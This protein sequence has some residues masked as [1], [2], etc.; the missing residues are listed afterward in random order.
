MAIGSQ[1][2]VTACTG[3]NQVSWPAK[4][5]RRAPRAE[6]DRLE[7]LLVVLI[8]DGEVGAPAVAVRRLGGALDAVERLGRGLLREFAIA[9]T[10]DCPP[11]ACLTRGFRRNIF[12]S[13]AGAIVAV[14]SLFGSRAGR[15]DGKT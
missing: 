4:L 3:P 14:A 1:V 15:K 5:P 7:R 11:C 6:D 2:V 10:V 8:A 13:R 12:A 9:E